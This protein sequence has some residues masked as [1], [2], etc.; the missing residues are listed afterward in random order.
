MKIAQPKILFSDDSII[1]IDKPAHM[2]S[3]NLKAGESKTLA[4]WLLSKYPEQAKLPSGDLQAGLIA[5]LDNETSGVIV[6]ART[7]ESYKYLREI[8]TTK[9]VNKEYTALVIGKTLKNG[10]IKTPIAHHP[11]K[12]DRMIVCNDPSDS[13]KYK[14]RNALTDFTNLKY[15]LLEGRLITATYSLL[16]VKIRAG[17]RH[18]IRVHMS[19]IGHPV[20]GDKIYRSREFIGKDNLKIGRHFLHSSTTI[21]RHPISN[22]MITFTAPLPDKLSRAVDTLT[23]I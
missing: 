16:N 21:F 17:V 6:A 5:R 9:R 4:A 12:K 11:K 23:E 15:Y 7:E 10:R 3:T 18:Q 22:E 13:R 20:A 2:P 8:W 1:V 19:S 14:G